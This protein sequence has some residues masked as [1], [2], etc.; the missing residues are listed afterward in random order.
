LPTSSERTLTRR[1]LTAALAARQL[2]L[3]RARITP[4]EAIRR[5][6]PLQGQDPPAPFVALAARLDGFTREQLHAALDSRQVMKTTLMRLTLHLTHEADYA[7]Y[8]ELSR[9]PWMRWWRK[10]YTHLDEARV[11]TELRRWLR[12]PRTNDEIRARVHRYGGV[13]ETDWA[14]VMFARMVVPL[15]Q[16]PPAG[17]WNDPRRPRFV[18]DPRRRPGPAA[19][20]VVVLE[21]YL[22]AFGPASRKDVSAWAGV[23][24]RDLAPAFTQ[25]RTVTYRDSK[26]VELFDL[27]GQPLPP[28][29]TRLPVRMLARWDQPI[30]AYADRERIIPSELLAL[31]LGLSG[32]QTVTVDGRV[33]AS[34]RLER[35]RATLAVQVTPH[36]NIRRAAHSAIRA[37]ARRMARF[38]EPAARRV[39]VVGV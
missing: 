4:A 20:A 27:P 3:E 5:L 21:R 29:S 23:T 14:P 36:V 28:A 13:P 7:A 25:L 38:C 33:A 11:T 6:T 12:T 37:E 18:V 10:H 17:F 39:E 35:G 34:W 1:E 22:R 24:Q 2:L 16:L 15:V 32:D 8:A 19:A 26:G 31:N 30:L 9:Q